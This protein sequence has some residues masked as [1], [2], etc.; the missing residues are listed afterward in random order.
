MKQRGKRYVD[1]ILN[2]Q[3]EDGWLFSC[4]D[5]GRAD[6][7]MW[8]LFLILKVLALYEDLTHDP[9]IELAVY[10]ALKNLDRHN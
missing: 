6:Y 10:R 1:A 4:D 9:Q 3:H 7:G 8:A 2:E 5:T